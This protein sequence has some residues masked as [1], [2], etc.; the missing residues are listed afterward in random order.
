MVTIQKVTGIAFLL[1]ISFFSLLQQAGAESMLLNPLPE[2][3]PS[4]R[5]KH[6][7]IYDSEHN[8]LVFFGGRDS[9][10]FLNDVWKLNLNNLSWSN[11]T[12]TGNIPS[13]RQ[14]SAIYDP[15]NKRMIVFGGTNPD[16]VYN[17][18]YA[19]DLNTYTWSALSPAGPLPNPRWNHSAIYNPADSSMVIF[20]GRDVYNWFN[21]LWKLDLK[22]LTWIQIIPVGQIPSPR[23]CHS[24]TYIPTDN[25][26]LVFGA[27]ENHVYKND[28]WKFDFT[29]NSWSQIFSAGDIPLERG[30]HSACYDSLNNRL[31]IFG[32]IGTNWL[33]YDDVWELDL[34]SF[35]WKNLFP[36]VCRES[37]SGIYDSQ[38]KGMIIFGG[39]SH[40]SN[41]IF[42]D[43][44]ILTTDGGSAYSCGD[45]NCDGVVSIIDIVY[46]INYLF[47]GG[48][49]PCSPSGRQ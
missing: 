18:L 10:G 36:Q 21:D 11:V 40:P 48:P 7:A 27:Y 3:G 35:T 37:Q 49:L 22:T 17:D 32:G 31:V 28:L 25:Y 15:L 33:N 16:Y 26:M 6:T 34:S 23:E 13:V 29:S 2:G 44:Y 5:Y 38:R 47:R 24:A 9:V 46:T 1:A 30:S 39:K 45:A 14:S 20:G 42:G 8:E 43:G 4:A 41:Y 19:L 12:V